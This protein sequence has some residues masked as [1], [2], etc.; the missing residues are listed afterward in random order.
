MWMADV[1]QTI[2]SELESYL[3]T[4]ISEWYKIARASTEEEINIITL[5]ALVDIMR[6]IA[7][8][9]RVHLSTQDK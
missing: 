3:D 8:L 5:Q 7:R 9:K 6:E 4:E 2:L 1:Y